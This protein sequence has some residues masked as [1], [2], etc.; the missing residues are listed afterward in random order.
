MNTS[1]SMHGTLA[2][3]LFSD[4]KAHKPAV[5]LSH[6]ISEN[7]TFENLKSSFTRR[8]RNRKF[9]YTFF[10]F[11]TFEKRTLLDVSTYN[12]LGVNDFSSEYSELSGFSNDVS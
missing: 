8:F 2:E 4:S 3:Y 11:L 1:M 12:L 9:G 6:R 5:I 7:E 10:G